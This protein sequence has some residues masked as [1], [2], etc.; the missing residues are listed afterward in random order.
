MI[1]SEDQE[2]GGVWNMAFLD[3]DCATIQR[4]N[5][6]QTQERGRQIILA[7][8]EQLVGIYG[9]FGTFDIDITECFK[10]LGFIVKV[11]NQ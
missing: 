3:A 1:A 6:A 2:D 7:P 9:A 5:P 11:K 10:C 8:D 4:Y